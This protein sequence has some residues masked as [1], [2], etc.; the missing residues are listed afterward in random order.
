M[1]VIFDVLDV[2]TDSFSNILLAALLGYAL[3]SLIFILLA[4]FG[5]DTPTPVK[6][7]LLLV[8][9][10]SYGFLLFVLV[11]TWGRSVF[12][13][14]TLSF[15]LSTFWIWMAWRIKSKKHV[16]NNFGKSF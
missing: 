10:S 4:L 8:H 12:L 1:Y 15:F 16:M 7:F 11:R 9:L 2:L 5:A 14:M 6:L 13:V 3:A